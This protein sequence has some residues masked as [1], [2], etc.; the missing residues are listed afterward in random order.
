MYTA[1][2]SSSHGITMRVTN[3][4]MPLRFTTCTRHFAAVKIV[5]GVA[6]HLLQLDGSDWPGLC[7][8]DRRLKV[9]I[10]GMKV[11]MRIEQS[12]AGLDGCAPAACVVLITS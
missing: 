7:I 5:A 6:P 3:A 4:V 12:S 9:N 11:K 8:A 1:L 2:Q 10:N